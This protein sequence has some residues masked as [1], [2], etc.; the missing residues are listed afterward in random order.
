MIHS[1]FIEKHVRFI[2]WIGLATWMV[3]LVALNVSHPAPSMGVKVVTVSRSKT[4]SQK[5]F[6]LPDPPPA[7]K[8]RED[9]LKRLAIAAKRVEPAIMY[10]G[11][12]RGD[13]GTAFVV[14]REHRLL[15][16]NAHI[17]EIFEENG[18][19]FAFRNGT[20]EVY[21]VDRYWYHPDYLRTK[22]EGTVVREGQ[23]WIRYRGN[24][25]ADVAILHLKSDGPVLPVECELADPLEPLD[26]LARH[27][28]AFGFSSLEMKSDEPIA[29]VFK[30]GTVTLLTDFKSRQSDARHWTMIDFD[31]VTNEGDSGGPVF[32]NDGRIHGV[33]AWSR[34]AKNNELG[35][36][37]PQATSGAAIH[38]SALWELLDFHGLKRF[39]GHEE[40]P[41]ALP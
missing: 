4:H 22:S 40:K 15:A 2:R 31:A 18:G 36:F 29:A 5:E 14:S 12:P 30:T 34:I 41:E 3:F 20:N 9:D 8:L 26:I 21:V 1:R 33:T 16:T 17:A 25:S 6:L 10:V 23:D 19:M 13:S 35:G 39:V 11:H 24:L 38:I 27:V 28:S 32:T 37:K 7:P